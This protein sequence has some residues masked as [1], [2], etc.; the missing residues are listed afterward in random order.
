MDT[1]PVLLHKTFSRNEVYI[2]SVRN[3]VVSEFL[4][5]LTSCNMVVNKTTSVINLLIIQ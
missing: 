5:V 3:L 2:S 1:P 4:T